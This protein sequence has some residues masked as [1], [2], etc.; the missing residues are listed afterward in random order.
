VGFTEKEAKDAGRKIRVGQFPYRA[1]GKARCLGETEGFVK[2]IGDA[3]TDEL[4]GVHI[5]GAHASDLVGE[6]SCSREAQA[7]HEDL[8][9]ST[10]VPPT[11]SEMLAEAALAA[12]GRA[13]HLAYEP[14]KAAAALLASKA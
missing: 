11:L 10:H 5:V 9:L 14:A 8:P 7:A 6:A 1:S 3:D 4:L 12:H 2:V 13:I